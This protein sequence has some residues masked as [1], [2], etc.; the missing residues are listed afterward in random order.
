MRVS[1]YGCGKDNEPF[2][3]DARMR[4][5]NAHSAV[6]SISADVEL[7]QKLVVFMP[8]TEEDEKCEVAFIADKSAGKRLVGVIFDRPA[9]EF[10]SISTPASGIKRKAMTR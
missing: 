9:W 10:L 1:I 2:R 7:G 6:L 8:S 4:L 5:A 3:E